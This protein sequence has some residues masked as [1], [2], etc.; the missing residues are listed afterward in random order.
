MLCGLPCHPQGPV[1]LAPLLA[2]RLPSVCGPAQT[3]MVYKHWVLA[4]A[5]YATQDLSR[6]SVTEPAFYR[7]L[8]RILVCSA[9]RELR[10]RTTEHCTAPPVALPPT[11]VY[12]CT[13]PART[14]IPR[15]L[16]HLWLLLDSPSNG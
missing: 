5:S 13:A 10:A 1:A 2:C 16:Q 6:L 7:K 3:A 15:V 4:C 9:L 11:A 8:F 14:A 12:Y